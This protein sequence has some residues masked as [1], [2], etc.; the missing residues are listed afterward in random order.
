MNICF[1]FNGSNPTPLNDFDCFA[2]YLIKK[3]DKVIF[4]V[5][6]EIKDIVGKKLSKAPYDSFNKGV[7][8]EKNNYKFKDT[9]TKIST[10]SFEKKKYFFKLNNF[11][12]FIIY[13]IRK[14]LLN[15]NTSNKLNKIFKN[16][17]PDLLFVYSDQC[18]GLTPHAIRWMRKKNRKVFEL[19]IA[20]SN[21]NF[22]LQNRINSDENCGKKCINRLVNLFYPHHRVFHENR[23]IQYYRW[24]DIFVLILFNSVP[25]YPWY[26]GHSFSD[27]LFIESQYR[28]RN[29]EYSSCRQI[30]NGRIDFD[31]LHNYYQNVSA[32]KTELFNKYFKNSTCKKSIIL[33]LPQF[34]EHQLMSNARA[35]SEINYFIQNI[36]SNTNY[37]VF[38]SLHPKMDYNDYKDLNK[39]S[40]R[41]AV[42]EKYSLSQ[43][44]MIGDLFF[45]YFPSTISYAIVCGVVPILINYY[46]LAEVPPYQSLVTFYDKKN[47]K[48]DLARLMNNIQHV[49]KL[50]DNDKSFFPT[51]DGKVKNNLYK[52]IKKCVAN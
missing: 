25:K 18:L 30:V 28:L 38:I 49:K 40:S 11:T 43:F 2:K 39:L 21:T 3:G 22:L 31:E 46:N 19:Q 51:F 14:V 41:I 50:V 35:R 45:T 34:A 13:L 16:F 5:D 12:K 44:I 7:L 36:I 1:L 47:I 42:V 26:S 9:S 52:H 27:Y 29:F 23:P 24:T 33:S 20:Y 37:Y 15:V 6:G 48:D 10:D 4:I 17:S 8:Y 32:I